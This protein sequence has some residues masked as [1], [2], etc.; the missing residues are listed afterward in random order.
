MILLAH[1]IDF[2]VVVLE[3]ARHEVDPIRRDE[4]EDACEMIS[5][6]YMCVVCCRDAV[7]ICV[8]GLGL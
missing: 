3:H 5:C 1:G 6:D 2:G 4:V 7:C 8:L